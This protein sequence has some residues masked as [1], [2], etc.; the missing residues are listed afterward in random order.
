MSAKKSIINWSL[1]KRDLMIR[2]TN[3][4]S[5]YTSKVVKDKRRESSRKMCRGKFQWD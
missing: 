4:D 1:I 5:R 2:D 3:L